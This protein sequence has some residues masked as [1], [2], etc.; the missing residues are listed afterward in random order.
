MAPRKHLPKTAEAARNDGCN[1]VTDFFKKN[2]AGRPKKR[3]NSANDDVRAQ[4]AISHKKK[5]RGPI[6]NRHKKDAPP[7]LMMKIAKPV[8]G[9]A[10]ATLDAPTQKTKKA[11]TNWG[12]GKAKLQLEKAVKEWDEKGEQAFDGN[13][14]PLQLKAF[15][16]VVGIPYDTFKKYVTKDGGKRRSLGKSVGRAP[17]IAEADQQFL[18]DVLARKDRGNDGASPAEAIDYVIEISPKL[19]R[20]QAR[21]HL[22]RT[23]LRNHPDQ[24]KPKPKVA[25]ATT[26]K[27]SAITVE[28]QFRWHATYDSCLDELKKRN[29]GLCQLTGLK[30]DELI[31]HFIVGADETCMMACEDGK[32]LV[33][34][35]AGRKKHEKKTNDSRVSITM[36]RTGTVA[37]DTGPT[38]FL[39][40]GIRKRPGFTDAFLESKC[41]AKLGS[42][43]IMTPNA[44]MTI[45]AWEAMTPS[46][47]KGLRNINKFVAA[48]PQWW[49]LEIFDGFGAHLLSFTAMQQRLDNKILSLKEEGDSSHVNQ[50]YDKFVAKSDK[51]AKG[52]GLAMLRGQKLVTKGVVDQWGMV[53]VGMMA[54]RAATRETWTRSYHACNLDPRTRVSF[55]DWCKKI[56][57]FLQTGQSFKV[58]KDLDKYVLLPSFWHG[59]KP[60][61]KKLVVSVVEKH[62]SYTVE[63]CRELQNLCHVPLKDMQHLRVCIQSAVECPSQLDRGAPADNEMAIARTKPALLIVAEAELKH[64]NDGLKSFLLKPPG[65]TGPDLFAHLIK[66]REIS[67][68][69]STSP[70]RHLNLEISE[71]NRRVL[72]TTKLCMT[73]REIM[74]EAG[75]DGATMKLSARRLDHIG[76]V[77]SH[78]GLVNSEV[79]MNAFKNQLTL[80]NSVAL[81][82]EL[83]KAVAA[84]KAADSAETFTSSAPTALARLSEKNGD[85]SK[86]TKAEIC[87]LLFSCYG[88]K[89][90]EK[91]H[92]K[93]RLIEMLTDKIRENPEAVAAAVAVLVAPVATEDLVA[94]TEPALTDPA[95]LRTNSN[96]G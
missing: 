37:G 6:P 21:Q 13:G 73:K 38:V 50:G 40:K 15:S 24:V 53:L 69:E 83:E 51:I 52:V 70:S 87:C 11:R 7:A 26:T 5:K 2:R 60:T 86:L 23:L 82:Q 35:S 59:M 94:T 66:K 63:C 27:R 49:M 16:K 34:G 68:A 9:A 78:S 91:K 74:K 64:V 84:K 62:G 61:E 71:S 42:T 8:G 20:D 36:Y 22:N 85:V 17:L 4:P 65:L 33:I 56:E 88:A 77:K 10:V 48:N 31:H 92:L 76:Q 47:C 43:I 41:E 81:I 3:G 39:L 14:E 45:D 28:Q 79:A 72:R 30:F 46:I 1:L 44:F 96:L 90:D 80:A 29:T 54:V 93:P 18:A 75:G 57:H 25:Q 89:I 67:H 58:E 95:S 55:P 19:T 32:I 12:Q